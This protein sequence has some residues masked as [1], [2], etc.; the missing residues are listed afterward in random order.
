MGRR[1]KGLEA[2][3]LFRSIVPLVYW[4]R[5]LGVPVFSYDRRR[6]GELFRIKLVPPG[7]IRPAFEKDVEVTRRAVEESYGRE[8]ADR[9]FGKQ[10]LVLL[11][12][13]QSIDASDEV[14]VS[15]YSIGIR[16]YDIYSRKWVFKPM[17]YGVKLI[18]DEELA[19]FI[20]ATKTIHED[21]VLSQGDYRGKPPSDLKWIPIASRNQDVY[22]LGKNMRDGRIRVAKVWRLSRD[23]YFEPERK[24][25]RDLVEANSEHLD[26]LERDAIEFLKTIDKY[27]TPLI[28]ISGGK[29]STSA[30][31][32]AV[33]AGYNKAVFLDTGIEFPETIETVEKVVEKL[34]LDLI[35]IEAGDTF[36]RALSVYGPP[37]RD[38]RWCCKVIK[39]S[40]VARV[41]K[42]K[43]DRIVSI[44]G[45]RR[46]ESTSR[47][48]AGRLAPSG[49]TAFD[50]IAAPIQNWTSLEVF[51]YI[52]Y[53][54]LPLNPLYK[55]GYER[56]GCYLCPTSRLAEI[57][58]VRETH[59]SLWDRWYRYLSRYARET[60]LPRPWVD[61]GLWRWRFGYPSEIIFLVKKLGLK[62]RDIIETSVSHY[63][64]LAIE[65]STENKLCKI[66]HLHNI[67][68]VD[69]DKYVK[70]LK[71]TG[72]K[73]TRKDNY[74]EVSIGEHKARVY[75]DGR[76]EVCTRNPKV[77]K[78]IIKKVAPMIFMISLCYGCG[79]CQIT[80][81]RRA[82]KPGEIE[83]DK[84]DSCRKC[85][86]VCPSASSFT[87]N[88]LKLIELES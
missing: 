4:S 27:G 75:N 38:Y 57:D 46:Y 16:E 48:L 71:I 60:R 63:A 34:G 81:P 55:M 87:K 29:D 70:Y 59:R 32:T 22:G 24:T 31:Y 33:L 61:Y 35:R 54:G 72:L 88:L 79:L 30:A 68:G 44:V 84:C 58:A 15:G 65:V 39:L 47:A 6:Y 19:P 37:A 21:D 11:N 8:L 62:A 25:L 9:V 78:S 77:V 49:S 51:M 36:W 12:K 69:L 76:I 14:I 43:F 80:C 5:D 85:I 13:V 83:P 45:Q 64:S 10:P 42:K 40:F 52:E 50:Y 53:R 67:R 18:A 26:A 73:G 28:N 86:H 23:F 7:D 2:T 74:V 82:I 1:L 17:Y 20:V 56:I 3:R 41:L 66:I